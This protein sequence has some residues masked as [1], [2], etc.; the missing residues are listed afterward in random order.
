MK[1]TMDSIFK[2]AFNVELN[3]LVGLD[4]QG[5]KFA[6]AFDESSR[7][8]SRRFAN[9]FWKI[10]RFLNIGSERLLKENI[11]IVD[12]FVYKLILTKASNHNSEQN[13]DVSFAVGNT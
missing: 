7:L 4:E 12:D 1:T 3:S 13:Y 10:M 11:K 6:K 8:I 9:I 5:V 2:V